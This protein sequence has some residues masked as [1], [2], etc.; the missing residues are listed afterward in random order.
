LRSTHT[1]T[2]K[3]MLERGSDGWRLLMYH[4]AV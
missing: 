3:R 4:I 1:L 2:T